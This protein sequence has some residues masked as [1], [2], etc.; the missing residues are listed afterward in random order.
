MFERIGGT[1]KYETPQLSPLPS[2]IDSVRGTGKPNGACCDS[3]KTDT[4]QAYEADE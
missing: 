2:A 3:A 4:P 1:M